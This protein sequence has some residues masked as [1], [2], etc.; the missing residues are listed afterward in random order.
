MHILRLGNFQ[1]MTYLPEPP[2]TQVTENTQPNGSYG[3]LLSSRE[4]KGFLGQHRV[5][6]GSG[7]KPTTLAH[8]ESLTSE[9][10]VWSY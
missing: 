10:K 3:N 7:E 9:K 2:G 5:N 6:G 8:S 4:E 1:G